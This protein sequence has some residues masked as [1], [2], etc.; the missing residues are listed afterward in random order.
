M[1]FHNVRL[2]EDVE[3][4]ANGG[5][6]FKTSVVAL[7]TGY[8]QRNIDFQFAR[9]KYDISYGIQSKDDFSTVLEFFY[10]RRGMAH[11]FRFKDWSD[12]ELARQNIGTGD[13]ADATWQIY[14]YYSD[15]AGNYTRD[16]TKIVSGS[17]SVWVNNTLKTIVT[18]YNVNYDTG[19]IT[20]TG[21]NIPAV[22]EAIEV[23]CEFDV[24]V[25]FDTDDFGVTLETFQAGAIPNIT[26]I[27]VRGE[28]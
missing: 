8:E 13:G 28:S 15:S 11:S 27:E 2:P 25:R 1:A 21:G 23:A 19:V 9:C 17:V 3:R 12:F 10:C 7:A 5:P 26:I 20:F 18:H 4:G 16:L 24:P 14:K 22:A 6:S